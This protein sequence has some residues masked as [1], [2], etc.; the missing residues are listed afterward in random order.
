MSQWTV[1]PTQRSDT[2]EDQTD[3]SEY[4]LV[5]IWLLQIYLDLD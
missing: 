5:Y 2:C 3:S 4:V 1:T